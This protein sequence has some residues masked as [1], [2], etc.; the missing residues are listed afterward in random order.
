[1]AAD[2]RFYKRFNFESVSMEEYEVRDVAR[3]SETPDLKL[4]FQYRAIPGTPFA[5]LWVSALNEAPEP[6]NHAV[7]RIY[8]DARIDILDLGGFGA[9][10]DHQLTQEHGELPVR[11]LSMNWSVPMKMPLWEGERFRLS[12]IPVRLGLPHGNGKWIIGW[13]ANAPRMR[14]KQQYFT[15]LWDGGSGLR[16]VPIPSERT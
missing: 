6:A 10:I 4:D 1:M 2:H 14:I 7:L 16:F 8:I 12:D 5:E 3:R 13:S 9:P 15:V 11:I